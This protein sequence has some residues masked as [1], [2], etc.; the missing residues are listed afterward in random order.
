MNTVIHYKHKFS[1][2]LELLSEMSHCHPKCNL[3]EG[4]LTY[5]PLPWAGVFETIVVINVRKK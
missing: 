2:K 5:T 1:H 3:V 4:F